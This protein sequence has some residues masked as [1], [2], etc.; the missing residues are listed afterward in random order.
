M[1]LN[2][3]LNAAPLYAVGI[4]PGSASFLTPQADQVLRNARCIA[5]Y[6]LYLDLLKPEFKIGKKIITTGMRQERERCHQ[7][8]AAALA[9][10]STVIISS[11]DAGI[12]GMA[13]LVLELL[14][15]QNLLTSIPFE[16]IAGVPALCAAAARVGAPIGHD[17]ACVSLSN[18]LTSCEVITRRLHAC[19]AADLVCVLYN[20]RSHGRTNCLADAIT[21]A[22]HYRQSACPVAL[23]RN[24]GRNGE[25]ALVTTLAEFDPTQADMLSLVIIG[26]SESRIVGGYMLTPR[27]YEEKTVATDMSVT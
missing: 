23:C 20:P 21:I 16:V 1:L 12:Y 2:S 15:Q 6:D 11:G 22:S 10:E 19:F 9:G 13:S 7:A 26:N 18:L 4:G 24:I 5:G 3:G 8:I 25:Q 17:F 27:G 14:A